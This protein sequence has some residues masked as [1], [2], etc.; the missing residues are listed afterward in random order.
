MAEPYSLSGFL[1]NAK[2]EHLGQLLHGRNLLLDV[3]FGALKDG[4]IDRAETA[5]RRLSPEL[6]DDCE[7]T[8]LEI[9]R[10]GSR[11][12]QD[13]IIAAAQ[14]RDVHNPADGDL[15]QRLGGM[16]GYLDAAFWT[17]LNRPQY[18]EVACYLADADAL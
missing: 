14:A 9:Y 7:A 2:Q 17:F 10:M 16:D 3:P 15:R 12:G 8:F 4:D 6:R 13:A 1:L 18:W 11:A 5:I